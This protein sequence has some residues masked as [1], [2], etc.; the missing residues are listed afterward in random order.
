[1]EKFNVSHT[2][3]ARVSNP[4]PEPTVCPHCRGAVVLANNS[5]IYGKAYG[6]WPW[7]YR[8]INDSCDSYVGLHPFT[9]FP[10]GTLADKVTRNARKKAKNAF[11]PIWQSKRMSRSAAYIWLAN[12]LGIA[13][14][15]ACHFGW[16]DVETCNRVLLV[17]EEFERKF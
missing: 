11:N 6:Q 10:L 17:C 15:N 5:K 12:K 1:L 13:D 4:L 14:V 2:A 7:V 9:A 16:F 8:C 3:I